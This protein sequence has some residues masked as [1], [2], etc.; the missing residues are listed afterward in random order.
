MHAHVE[1]GGW[2]ATSSANAG[3]TAESAGALACAKNT[4]RETEIGVGNLVYTS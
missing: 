1:L 2:H 3:Y 4:D